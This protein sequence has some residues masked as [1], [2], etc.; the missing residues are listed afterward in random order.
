VSDT[1]LALAVAVTFMAGIAYEIAGILVPGWHTI[2]YSGSRSWLLRV[3]ILFSFLAGA[4]WWWGHSA[5][6]FAK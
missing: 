4:A 2:S 6:T 3:V 1:A 5:L